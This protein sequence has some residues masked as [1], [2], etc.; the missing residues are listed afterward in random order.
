DGAPQAGRA[1]AMLAVV[2]AAQPASDPYGALLAAELGRVAAQ[3]PAPLFHDDLADVDA[4]WPLTPFA[5]PAGEHGIQSLA[6]ADFFEM[7]DQLYPERVV[8]ALREWCRD[9]LLAKEQYLDFLKCRRFRQTLLC[10]ADV[11]LQRDL[12]PARLRRLHVAS[13][14]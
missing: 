12:A 11:P 4:P 14:V 3:D 9:D 1:T 13:P 2:A 5:G 10:H 6:E 8:S 7:Q